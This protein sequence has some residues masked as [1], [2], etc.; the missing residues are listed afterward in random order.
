[1]LISPPKISANLFVLLISIYLV[2]VFNFPFYSKAFKAIVSLENFN[3]LFLLSVPV[4]LLS[5]FVLIISVFSW[6]FLLKPLA[7]ALIMLSVFIFYGSQNYGII[8]DYGMIQ[9]TVETDYSEAIS[10]LNPQSILTVL[11]LGV[12]PSFLISITPIKWN[13]AHKEL[14]QRSQLI[15][16]SLITIF[17]IAGYFYSNYAAVGRNNKVLVKY[18]IPFKFINASYKY[19]RNNYFQLLCLSKH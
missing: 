18:I 2:G 10:Y 19:A 14:W 9:N 7:I 11:L 17:T 13:I 3:V 15:V 4:L 5:L 8:F 12:L 1:M 6:R 16:V